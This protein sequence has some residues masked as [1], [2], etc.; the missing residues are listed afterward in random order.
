MR[1]VYLLLALVLFFP[2]LAFSNVLKVPLQYSNIQAA[3]DVAVDG[4]LVLV[5]PGTYTEQLTMINKSVEL[6]SDQ[7]GD[8]TTHDI[9]TDQTIVKGGLTISESPDASLEG[10]TFS[11]NFTGVNI[12]NCSPTLL[13]NKI[14][15]CK[16]GIRTFNS[17]PTII[18]NSISNNETA[19]VG[20]TNTSAPVIMYNLITENGD[21]VVTDESSTVI[22]GFN[23]IRNNTGN[24]VFCENMGSKVVHNIIEFNTCGV[25]MVDF[26]AAS[27]E[28]PV[29]RG[30]TIRY[31]DNGSNDGGGI[32]FDLLDETVEPVRISSNVIAF[33]Q[34]GKGAGIYISGFHNSPDYNIHQNTIAYNGAS[35]SGGGIHVTG[36]S[37]VL[38]NTILWNN[39]SPLGTQIYMSNTTLP[40]RVDVDYCDVKTGNSFIHKDAGTL[41]EWGTAIMHEDPQF[42]DELA[43]DFHLTNKSGCIN[44]GMPLD[45]V[46]DDVDFDV[47]PYAGT[48]ELGA[49][50]YTA[51]HA[52]QADRYTYPSSGGTYVMYELNAGASNKNRR[53]IIC[54]SASGTLPGMSLGGGEVLPLNWDIATNI[55]VQLVLGGYPTFV[56][57]LGYLNQIGGTNAGFYLADPVPPEMIGLVLYMAFC[58]PS[59]PPFAS[60]PV[61][62]EFVP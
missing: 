5:Q 60:N 1:S 18:Y 16:Y 7:D 48:P 19:G 30:N 10:F 15:Y 54:I 2:A 25:R 34:A 32:C 42:V 11:L 37:L 8:E 24:G 50:E 29:V 52:L 39:Q 62:L 44:R 53:Y 58:M 21:G 51:M 49:D 43:G 22:V 13:F 46:E 45:D 23:Y 40:T 6:R 3:L 41:L 27:D 12:Y 59:N 55:C 20:C 14:I 33:N 26:F 4:D 36:S 17:A 38:R 35:F 56:G 57:F 28:A 9:A 47:V 61:Q 31:N